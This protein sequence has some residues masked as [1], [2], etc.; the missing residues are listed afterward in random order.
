[1]QSSVI[2]QVVYEDP[3]LLFKGLNAVKRLLESE[4][5]NMAVG[6]SWVIASCKGL[7]VKAKVSIEGAEGRIPIGGVR[8]SLIIQAEGEPD[9]LVRASKMALAVAQETGGGLL[10]A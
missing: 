1:M 7:L 2:F 3:T 8:G 5:C 10:M 9:D 4:G 6:A